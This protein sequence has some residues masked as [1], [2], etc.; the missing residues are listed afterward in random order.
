MVFQKPNLFP[1]SIY[2]NVRVSQR[3]AF[4][5]MGRVVEVGETGKIPTG[6]GERRKRDYITERF[7][8]AR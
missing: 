1:K 4:F 6:P 7:G 3:T 8:S 2:D 5:P